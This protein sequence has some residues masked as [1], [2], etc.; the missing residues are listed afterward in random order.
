MIS[1]EGEQEK[2][3]HDSDILQLAWFTFQLVRLTLIP[4]SSASHG[5]LGV[6]LLLQ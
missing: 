3:V 2:Q 4:A 6:S 1:F 5:D